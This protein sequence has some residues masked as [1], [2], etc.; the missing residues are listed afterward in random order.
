MQ[1][2]AKET[3]GKLIELFDDPHG[4]EKFQAWVEEK[5]KPS[6]PIPI[7]VTNKEE[8]DFNPNWRSHPLDTII[9]TAILKNIAF[10]DM[11]YALDMNDQQ[12][13]DFLSEKTPINERIAVG[14]ERLL[15]VDKQF[16]INRQFNYDKPMK[17]E[18]SEQK[19]KELE[20]LVNDL[21]ELIPKETMREILKQDL[22]NKSL[23]ELFELHLK[24]GSKKLNI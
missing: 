17:N 14:L 13:R 18:T 3:L 21:M 19:I 12:L 20:L 1:V 8:D 2:T 11:A 22:G 6:D 15:G 4:A 5:T 10:A 24:Y 23:P 9:E 16:W 7:S